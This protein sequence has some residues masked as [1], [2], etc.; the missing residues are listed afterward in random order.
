MCIAVLVVL[1][2]VVAWVS[3][4]LHN[5]E[6]LRVSASDGWCPEGNKQQVKAGMVVPGHTAILIDTS[7]RIDEA[8]GTAAFAAIDEVLRDTTRTPY[9]QRLSVYGLPESELE[10][11]VAPERSLCVPLQGHMADRLYQNPR[12]VNL[13]FRDF[14]GV[15]KVRLDSLLARD[16]APASPIIE[17]M[18][19]LARNDA[20]LDSF[21]VV[22]DMLQNTARCDLYS[23]ACD[24]VE[25]CAPIRNSGIDAVH[26]YYV[27][28]RI[29]QQSNAWPDRRWSEC[30]GSIEARALN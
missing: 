28:R 13:D 22:S 7:N 9:L 2:V 29:P 25:L 23:S 3:I 12:V 15:V 16:E 26:V 17:T 5:Q 21:I 30:L 10:R 14:V 19:E 20:E 18:A 1:A 11:P 8:N 6:Q 4:S 27:D 24:M